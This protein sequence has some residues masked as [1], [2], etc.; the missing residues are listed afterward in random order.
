MTGPKRAR[1]EEART[2][3][4]KRA[5][6]GV[7][8]LAAG[9]LALGAAACATTGE[10]TTGRTAGTAVGAL[11]GGV[12]GYQKGKGSGALKGALIGGAAGYVVGWLVDEY[13]FKKTK[14]AQQVQAE[15]RV[16]AAEPA[17]PAVHRYGVAINP[18]KRLA[19]GAGAEAVT[20]FDL[21]APAGTRPAVEEERSILAPDGTTVHTKRYAYKEV[22]GP[23]GYEFRHRLPVP[24]EAA[25]GVYTYRSALFLDGKQASKASS[26]FQVARTEG[27]GIAV[28]WLPPAARKGAAR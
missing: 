25:P 5:Q 4:R 28:A 15:Y 20:E 10:S 22:D 17:A 27:G 2:M 26:D 21:V 19:R 11:V 24:K 6:K 13:V 23:G 9:A 12:I 16:P 3:W 14:T 8:V 7:A 1:Q 18:D